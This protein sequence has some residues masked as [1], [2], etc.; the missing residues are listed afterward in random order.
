VPARI[1]SRAEF[2][3]AAG[4]SKA[5][6][7]KQCRPKG[8]LAAAAEGDRINLDHPAAQTYLAARGKAEQPARAPTKASKSSSAKAAAPTNPVRSGKKS[9]AA[10]TATRP[11]ASVPPPPRVPAPKEIAELEELRLHLAPLVHRFGTARNFR[12]WLL[13]LKDIEVVVEKH[14]SNE[15]AM[16][17]L[18]SRELVRG[19]IT[20]VL[21][22]LC[23]KLLTDAPKTIAR[24]LAGHFNA[25][26]TVE[27]AEV[28]VR[29]NLGSHVK[30]VKARILT[31]LRTA[32]S[33]V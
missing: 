4:V 20:G 25:S 14:L 26:G 27:E 17:R 32:D 13:S 6:I 29:E 31:A 19:Q 11:E 21:V 22:T 18:I 10:P 1:V 33:D 5:A 16:G 7:T 23:R 2:A 28:I 12:D 9:K 15:E 3:R 30:P 8:S 24:R